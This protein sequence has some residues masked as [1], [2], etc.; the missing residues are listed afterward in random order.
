[1]TEHAKTRVNSTVL[2]F[3]GELWSSPP[4]N[5]NRLHFHIDQIRVLMYD[6]KTDIVLINDSQL[7]SAVHES[8]VYRL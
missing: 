2:V 3:L 5:I 4:L 1:M 6:S 7:D 8:D